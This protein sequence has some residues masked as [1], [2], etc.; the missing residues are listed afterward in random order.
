M[1]KVVR[2]MCEECLYNDS[3]ECHADEIEVKSSAQGNIVVSSDGTCCSTF[4][5][6]R[7]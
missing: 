6:D 3:F 5:N 7:K 2:C 4:R 1:A